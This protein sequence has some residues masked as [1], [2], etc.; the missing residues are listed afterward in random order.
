MIPIIA[1]I[2]NH[3]KRWSSLIVYYLAT[4]A[5]LSLLSGSKGESV[6]MLTALFSLLQLQS[7][8]EYV[9]LLRF[10]LAAVAALVGSTIYYV[11][12]FLRLDPTQMVSIMGSRMFLANDARALAI[13][14][15]GH[16]NQ[17]STSLFRESFRFFGSLLGLAPV[18]PPLGQLL[19]MQAFSTVGML[20]ANTSA[21]ALL[22]A[23][24]SDFERVLFAA[25]LSSIA[26]LILLLIRRHNK[27]PIATAAIGI[28][29]LSLLSQDFL[30]FQVTV[31]ILILTGILAFACLL[32]RRSL[33]LASTL[34]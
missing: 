29:L 6:L 16:L 11:G 3:Q 10:P 31:N 26:S 23:Y 12:R 7:N 15:S 28:Y 34:T 8:G 22:I 32:I 30:A 13:D 14:Y 25:C 1:T 24:G 33:V 18:N 4:E 27:Y 19:Y 9:K 20:G 5:I 17:G 21:T 2:V